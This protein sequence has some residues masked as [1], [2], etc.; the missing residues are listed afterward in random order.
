MAPTSSLVRRAQASIVFAAT[1]SVGREAA[2]V[3]LAGVVVPV[4]GPDFLHAGVATT[5]RQHKTSPI[6]RVIAFGSFKLGLVVAAVPR[7]TNPT[8]TRLA[9]KGGQHQEHSGSRGRHA[10]HFHRLEILNR[11]TTLSRSSGV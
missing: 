3:G 6:R 8:R 2:G 9:Y 11:A 10:C 7:L 4:A 1:P 5:D